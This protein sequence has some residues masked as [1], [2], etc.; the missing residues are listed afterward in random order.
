MYKIGRLIDNNRLGLVSA[1]LLSI[2]CFHIYHSQQI[3]QFTFITALSM[4]SYYY[5]LK[6]MTS[7]RDRFFIYNVVFNIAVIFTHPYGLTVVIAQSLSALLVFG[8]RKGWRWFLYNIATCAGIAVWISLAD[9]ARMA[10]NVWWIKKP[11]IQSIVETV[12][13]FI[14]GGPRYGLDD[15]WINHNVII[16]NILFL[17]FVL[18]M[19]LGSVRLIRNN[20]RAFY[21]I[22]LWFVV[23]IA[24][25][26]LF[27][28]VLFPVFAIKHLMVALPPFLLLVASGI[29]YLQKR[30]YILSMLFLI[31]VLMAPFFNILYTKDCS[32]A[33]NKAVIYLREGIEPHDA[34]VIAPL[35]QLNSFLYYFRGEN[36]KGM[37][38]DIDTY[39]KIENGMLLQC[40]KEDKYYIIGI[41]QTQKR[42]KVFFLNEVKKKLKLLDSYK[43]ENFWLLIDRWMGEGEKEIILSILLSKGYLISKKVFQGIEVYKF[44]KKNQKY[45]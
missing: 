26:W 38:R 10:R 41:N 35:C 42:R 44:R 40:F 29:A 39:G 3:R 22:L 9:K 20:R 25:S 34:I 16:I 36:K 7:P 18:F 15:F 4:G 17:I 21:I 12:H 28:L 24:V 8:A 31:A 30:V 11:G 33:W 23:P 19:S 2:S 1:F 43:G 14:Y 27:S 6:I 32:I 13:T 5:F 37:L 45:G